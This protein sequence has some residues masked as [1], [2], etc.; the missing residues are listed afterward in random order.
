M[1]VKNK[2]PKSVKLKTYLATIL[3]I[4]I[5]FVATLTYVSSLPYIED[6]SE[7][8]IQPPFHTA[9]YIIDVYNSTHYCAKNGTTGEYQWFATTL[10]SVCQSA[11]D[12][13][14]NGGLII[15]R[16]AQKPDGLTIA[17]NVVFEV[18]YQDTM[19]YYTNSSSGKIGNSPIYVDDTF[20]LQNNLNEQ[21]LLELTPTNITNVYM[22]W[23]D[24][25]N[26]TQTCTIKAYQKVGASYEEN[27]AM[28]LTNIGADER[29]V[30]TLK[31]LWIVTDFKITIQNG[32]LEGTT[33][34]I[35]YR[36]FKEE[37]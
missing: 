35:S 24:I 20:T 3:L 32:V 26:L 27:K 34:I 10:L 15:I 7:V 13:L 22:L 37:W 1:N 33:R 31:S 5:V 19:K 36:Y 17:S 4:T 11:N 18:Y 9:N 16:N 14:A 30:L 21:T 2:I 23:L 25:S 29:G 6:I 28:R 8:W 12:D